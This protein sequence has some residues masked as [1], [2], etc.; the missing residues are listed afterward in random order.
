MRSA[1]FGV[2]WLVLGYF[3]AC[4]PV[5][6]EKA[7]E[8]D[9]GVEVV[10]KCEGTSCVQE[11]T[12]ERT[13]GR[14]IV[15]IL[16]INDNSVSMSPEQLKMADRFPTFLN[17]LGNIDYRIAMTTTD[18]SNIYSKT[19]TDPALQNPVR[20]GGVL[21]DGSLIDFGGGQMYLHP[22]LPSKDAMFYN[23]VQRKETAECDKS[24]YSNC[25]SSDERAI[26][27]ANLV[28]DRTANMFVRP[29]GHLAV[30]ILSD[31][32]ERG[33]SDSRSDRYSGDPQLRSMYPLEN[34]DRPQTFVNKFRAKYPG[35]TL[36]VHPIIIKPGDSGCLSAQTDGAN[37]IRGV[38]GYSYQ[39][40]KD[41]TGGTMGSICDSDYGQTMSNIGSYVQNSV[42]SLPFNCRPVAD[43]YQVTFSPQPSGNPRTSADFSKMVLNVIDPLPPMTKVT[44]KYDCAK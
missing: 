11:H 20:N 44:L 41:L 6:F 40:L 10:E 12:V 15:D 33:I 21:Q 30:V 32:D 13:V 7:P 31:E 35:K 9:D 28:M 29:T 38:E 27:A 37:Y 18:I 39:A 14:G 42:I 34:Y 1:K 36:S 5:Q 23:T 8:P 22:D 16:V 2:T 24:N 43:Q 3:V 19:P 17:S 25:P 4:A 26:F